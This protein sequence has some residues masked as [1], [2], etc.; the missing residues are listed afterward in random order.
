MKHVIIAA[1]PNPNSFTL[2]LARI[3]AESLGANGQETNLRDLYAIRFNPVLAAAEIAGAGP[4]R[5]VQEEQA[6]IAEADA[7][8]FVYPLWWG[9][10]PAMLKGYIDRV[11]SYGFAYKHEGAQMR[12]LLEGKKSL[13]VTL[14]AAPRAA[15]EKTGDWRAIHTLQDSHIFG[16]CGLDVVH[17]AHFDEIL[18]DLAEAK[19]QA[20]FAELLALAERYFGRIG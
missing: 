13:V 7:V 8:S 2:S 9:S 4:A 20:H 16:T 5:D 1:H 6:I 3:L 10:M 14:S 12:G 15:M 18:P 19:A 17:H 11:F